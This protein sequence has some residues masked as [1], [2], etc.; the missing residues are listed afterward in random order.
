MQD[1]NVQNP[2][3]EEALPRLGSSDLGRARTARGWMPLFVAFALTAA[4][5]AGDQKKD[6]EGP[7]EEAGE[8]ADEAADDTQDAAEEGADEAKDA[9]DDAGDAVEDATDN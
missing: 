3:A 2:S 9:A 1:R 6:A 5:C 8:A 4:G 7:A